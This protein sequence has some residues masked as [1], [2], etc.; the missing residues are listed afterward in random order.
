MFFQMKVHPALNKCRVN[1]GGGD[2][3]RRQYTLHAVAKGVLASDGGHVVVHL[4]LNDDL[5][6]IVTKVY[7]QGEE[8]EAYSLLPNSGAVKAK[9]K[10]YKRFALM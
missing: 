8:T 9:A 7:F 4:N 1:I 3:G 10:R 2:G 6:R 5:P